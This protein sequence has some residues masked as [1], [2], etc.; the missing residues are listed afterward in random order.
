MYGGSGSGKTINYVISQSSII[1]AYHQCIKDIEDD[2]HIPEKM[3]HHAAP[4][5]QSRVDGL[6][7]MF[8]ELQP[9]RY[10]R[11]QKVPHLVVD[12]FQKGCGQYQRGMTWWN[13]IAMDSGESDEQ[14]GVEV[15]DL[16]I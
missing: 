5:I 8:H 3:L 16:G 7:K 14:Y 1:N 10:E 11:A 6:K 13:T 4:D 15:G 12:H 9:H 2:F